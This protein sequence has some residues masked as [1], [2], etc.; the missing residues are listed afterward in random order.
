LPFLSYET[1]GS[2]DVFENNQ[3]G[4]FSVFEIFLTKNQNRWLSTK[5]KTHPTVISK[6]TAEASRLPIHQAS[7]ETIAQIMCCKVAT[8]R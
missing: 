2:F 8:L 1:T 7:D 6:K 3:N 5:S 4:S